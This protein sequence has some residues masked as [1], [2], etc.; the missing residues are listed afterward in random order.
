[1]E[2]VCEASWLI[3]FANI[4]SSYNLALR[5]VVKFAW[6]SD[7]QMRRRSGGEIQLFQTEAATKLSQRRL[8]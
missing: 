6:L 2:R 4:C 3:L 7:N 5:N 1:M 8:T